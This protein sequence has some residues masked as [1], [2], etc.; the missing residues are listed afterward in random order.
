MVRDQFPL[1]LAEAIT[2]HKSQGSSYDRVTIEL[3]SRNDRSLLYVALSRATSLEGLYLIGTFKPPNPDP[4]PE[5]STKQGKIKRKRKIYPCQ[6]MERLRKDAVFVPKFTNL[7]HFANGCLQIVS[8]NVRSLHAH[9]KCL[10]ADTV[11]LASNLALFQETWLKTS[12][13][14]QL[15][16]KRI[17]TR[18]M[19]PDEKTVAKGT[20]IYGSDDMLFESLGNYDRND[21]NHIDMTICKFRDIFIINI[22]KSPNAT[23]QNLE[24]TLETIRHYLEE[25][26]V[27]VCGDFN[28][29]LTVL[30]SPTIVLFMK[31]YNLKLLSPTLPTTDYGTCIDGVFGRLLDYSC[32]ITIYE[33]YFSDHKPIVIV[34]HTKHTGLTQE[35]QSINVK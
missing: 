17:I 35:I 29:D 33:S 26:N 8:H 30:D 24:D 27:L 4:L 9:A 11:V 7:T 19:L 25:P 22:Y 20:I 34:I 6:E 32:D 31:E 2:I 1:V 10:S 13:N 21:S 5:Q 3:P 12:S 28:D 18:N 16:S 23:K 15:P 14:E